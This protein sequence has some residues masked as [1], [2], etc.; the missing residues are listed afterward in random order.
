MNPS[1][2]STVEYRRC[3]HTNEQP[4][5]DQHH[6]N[7]NQRKAFQFTQLLKKGDIQNIRLQFISS[8]YFDNLPKVE[9][10]VKTIQ[11][12]ITNL[13]IDKPENFI[14]QKQI[15][16]IDTKSYKNDSI[17]ITTIYVPLGIEM[18]SLFPQY[19]AILHYMKIENEDKLASFDLKTTKGTTLEN[20]N[21]EV[22]DK[23]LITKKDIKEVSLMYEGGY[24]APKV[25]KRKRGTISELS[26]QKEDFEKLLSIINNSIIIKSRKE[27]DTR[28]FKGDPELSIINIGLKNNFNWTISHIISEEYDNQEDFY[29]TLELRYYEFINIAVTYWIEVK[30]PKELKL[31]MESLGKNASDNLRNAEKEPT[32]L[33][34][35]K[36]KK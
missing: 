27:F 6:Q 11:S 22:L 5:N 15:G 3:D 21:L 1:V 16:S 26:E 36:D 12:L 28:R 4:H 24:K 19:F 35:E 9:N 18:P 34:L 29:G 17:E 30:N 25:F 23:I 8:E 2:V 10:T 32:K 14:Y 33:I 7:L 20:S 31:L 13:E